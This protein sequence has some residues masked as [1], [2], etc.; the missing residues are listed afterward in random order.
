MCH[1]CP[2]ISHNFPLTLP[3]KTTHGCVLRFKYFDDRIELRHSKQSPKTRDDLA[4]LQHAALI[5]GGLEAL[6]NL[7]Q[8]IT[9]DVMHI[10]KI[11]Q[12][13]TRTALR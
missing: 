4:K 8:P 10:A 12:D 9:V 11:Q 13:L 7:P 3:C 6:N 5:F 2:G 1:L